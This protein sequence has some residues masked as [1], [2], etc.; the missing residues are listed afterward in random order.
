MLDKG[1]RLS[2]A[3]LRKETGTHKVDIKPLVDF[4]K[5]TREI[6]AALSCSQTNV[7]Y[8]LKKFKLQAHENRQ[9]QLGHTY[10]HSCTVCARHALS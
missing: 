8:W 3:G 5:S 7:R 10:I 6:A 9:K 2:Y 4:G 1:Y